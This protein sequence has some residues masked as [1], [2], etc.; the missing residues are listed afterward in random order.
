MTLEKFAV[1]VFFVGAIM[2][3]I[4]WLPDKLGLDFSNSMFC[5]SA[6]FIV[7]VIIVIRRG[8]HKD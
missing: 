7:A 1:L 6:A 5:L 8:L 2:A 4:F 3:A